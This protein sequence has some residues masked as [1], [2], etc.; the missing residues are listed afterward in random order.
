[1]DLIASVTD[2]PNLPVFL[3][4]PDLLSEDKFYQYL[5]ILVEFFSGYINYV[6][7]MNCNF[8]VYLDHLHFSLLYIVRR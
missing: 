5:P 4:L 3:F 1:M 6:P 7:S 2:I 8:L